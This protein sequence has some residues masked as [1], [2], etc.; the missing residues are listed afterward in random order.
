MSKIISAYQSTSAGSG[1]S[2]TQSYGG[3]TAQAQAVVTGQPADLV[4]LS[5]GTDVNL[6]VDHGLVDKNY[7]KQSY[8]GA[9]ANSVVV[10]AVRD[11]NP[12]KI[13]GW[14]DLLK[15]GVQVVTPNPFTC[16]HREVEHPGRVRCPAASRQDGQAGDRLRQGAV[17]A[18]RLAGLVGEQ[19]HEH[20]PLGQGRRPDHVRER[21]DQ[22]PARGQGHP[23]RDPAPDDADRAA[24]RGDEE[25]PEQGRGDLVHPLH[26]VAPG[27]GPVRS[28]RVPADRARM[29]PSSS[30]SSTRCGPA[31]SRST[32][33]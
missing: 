7:D 4:F 14:N 19:R 6:L 31:C 23:V 24:R 22:R 20:V 11:G 2:F 29:R 15:P 12:K 25:E 33:R 27:A 9:A 21:G 1:V 18:R 30:R 13:K 32:T 10:F 26:E 5:T 16:G 28:E 8:K 3:S 17:R